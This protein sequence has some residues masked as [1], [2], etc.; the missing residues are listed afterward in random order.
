MPNT[1]GILLLMRVINALKSSLVGTPA[2]Y[3]VMTNPRLGKV[4]EFYP[5][6]MSVGKVMGLRLK[7]AT[8]LCDTIPNTNGTLSLIPAIVAFKSSSVGTLASHLVMTNRKLGN[9]GADFLKGTF[10]P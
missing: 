6:V 10:D 3:L 2:S 7:K 9:V 1:N 4:Y 8:S 5:I